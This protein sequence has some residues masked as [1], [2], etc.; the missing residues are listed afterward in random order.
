MISFLSKLLLMTAVIVG[1][2]YILEMIWP[3]YQPGYFVWISV[4]FY[5]FLTAGLFSLSMM[6]L[7]RN[8]RTFSTAVFGSMT[9]RFIFCI[10][11]LVIYLII[12]KEKNV[13][14]IVTY[15]FLYLFYTIF[16]IFQLVRKLR[17]E[18]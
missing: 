5:F 14:F 9:I 11:F 10:L 7:K 1:A 18:K 12:N 4:A 6:G 16:E 15:L 3:E 17:P 2:I 8:N 13:A